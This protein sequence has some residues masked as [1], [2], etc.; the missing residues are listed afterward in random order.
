MNRPKAKAIFAGAALAM[1]P[2]AMHAQEEPATLHLSDTCLMHEMRATP[3]PADGWVES[4]RKISFQWPL[5]ADCPYVDAHKASRKDKTQLRYKVRYSTDKDLKKDVVEV[6]TRW[7]MYNPD[8]DLAAGR[9]YW[10]HGY[11]VPD[12]GS[13]IWSPVFSFCLLYTSPSPRD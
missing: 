12:D 4:G 10:Q 11:V 1:M 5:A 2:L 3:S 13:V 7:P 6:D 8:K 9:W